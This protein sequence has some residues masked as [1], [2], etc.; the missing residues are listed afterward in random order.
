MAKIIKKK[1]LSSIGVVRSFVWLS[2]QSLDFIEMS[3]IVV[4]DLLVI[5]WEP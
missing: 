2:V 3:V 4:P 1:L 5:T